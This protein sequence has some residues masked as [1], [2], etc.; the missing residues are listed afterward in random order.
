MYPS[1]CYIQQP[2]EPTTFIFHGFGG[3]KE[4]YVRLS[5]HWFP[6]LGGSH[7]PNSSGLYTYYKNSLLKVG[8]PKT[9]RGAYAVLKFL[10]RKFRNPPLE[11]TRFQ[12]HSAKPANVLTMWAPR[13][14]PPT[15]RGVEASQTFLRKKLHPKRLSSCVAPNFAKI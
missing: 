3:P 6:V 12:Q 10:R 14:A 2:W 11:R 15:L 13:F 1:G 5:T 4:S 8:V 9:L 7:Q